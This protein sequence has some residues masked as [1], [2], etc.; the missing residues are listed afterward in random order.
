MANALG[1]TYTGRL[2]ARAI[3]LAMISPLLRAFAIDFEQLD[4][5]L[6]NTAV[7]E[8]IK[9]KIPGIPTVGDFG[10]AATDLATTEVSVLLNQHKQV[11][12][13]LTKAEM[14]ALSLD[15]GDPGA[16]L[17]IDARARLMGQALTRKVASDLLALITTGNGY[18]ALADVNVG[19]MD[20]DYFVD[21]GATLDEDDR[22]CPDM[23]RWAMV[24]R[25]V[26]ANLLKD[27][28]VNKTNKDAGFDPTV[29]GIIPDVAGFQV[30]KCPFLNTANATADLEVIFGA[31][32]AVGWGSRHPLDPTVLF[33][34]APR[35]SNNEAM[36][37]AETGLRFLNQEFVDSKALTAGMRLSVL[38]GKAKAVVEH[39][40]LGIKA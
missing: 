23:G 36:V 4:P 29:T 30:I 39:A 8:S 15:Q 34:D 33:P 22:Y 7:G 27:A 12:H 3:Q 40:I 16:L 1:T 20:F 38:Y 21:A 31:P 13:D 14:Q 9:I 37:D 19:D 35:N 24:S 18:D 25:T 26:W 28:R 11:Q 10:D 6:P 5:G 32:S 2:A 17:V